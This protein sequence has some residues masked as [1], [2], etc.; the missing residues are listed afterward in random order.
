MRRWVLVGAL[1]AIVIAAL[2]LLR[3]GPA[4]QRPVAA[5]DVEAKDG[6]PG[7]ESGAAR[8]RRRTG[9]GSRP[10]P[11]S[12]GLS[13]AHHRDVADRASPP[14][15]ADGKPV[16]GA[17]ELIQRARLV[18]SGPPP[19]ELTDKASTVVNTWRSEDRPDLAE[20]VGVGE[21]KCYAAGCY[22][23]FTFPDM[24]TYNDFL[25][26]LFETKAMKHWDGG[27]AVVTPKPDG[28]GHLRAAWYVLVGSAESVPG[29]ERSR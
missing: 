25:K 20:R 29:G 22:T 12:G 14:T 13:A 18:E 8:P 5:D 23:E 7:G 19:R 24:E 16:L 2:A 6:D 28:E 26:G 1:A 9:A 17:G 3:A 4:H 21:T 10:Q 11:S 27:K 15:A